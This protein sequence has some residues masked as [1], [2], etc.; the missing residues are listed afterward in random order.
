MY[1][2][3]LIGC[4]G[5]ASTEA[6]ASGTVAA[7][8]AQLEDGIILVILALGGEG[9]SISW[10]SA[11]PSDDIDIRRSVETTT[12][13]S[14][15]LGEPIKGFSSEPA[16]AEVTWLRWIGRGDEVMLVV[17]FASSETSLRRCVP[18]MISSHTA[19][20]YSRVAPRL[21]STSGDSP[22]LSSVCI[23]SMYL[24]A[25]VSERSAR[26]LA[27]RLISEPLTGWTR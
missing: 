17:G 8:G 4:A 24:R 2:S 26:K 1:L 12:S 10:N 14:S 18:C 21:T 22:L 16:W 11:D 3:I 5:G 6:E 7:V 15:E 23:R 25:S 13:T 19:V 27:A 20:T 9:F